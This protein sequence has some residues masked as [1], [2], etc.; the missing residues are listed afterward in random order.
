MKKFI[1][2]CLTILISLS[3]VFASN[4]PDG[5][6]K[7]EVDEAIAAGLIPAELQAEY[8]N[9]TT[10][11]EFC[12]LA[13]KL[14]E[15]VY[16]VSV[17]QVLLGRGKNIAPEDTFSD[18][19]N[20]YVLA[21]YAL[22]ITK[23]TG[24]G[25]F[26]P[27]LTL[28]RQQAARL[29]MQTAIVCDFY[30][31][32][33][34]KMN[35]TPA[36]VKAHYD[37][38]FSD[39]S[40]VAPWARKGV[41]F[42]KDFDVM[43][44]TGNGRFSPKTAYQKQQS[45]ITVYRLYNKIKEVSNPVVDEEPA[46]SFNYQTSLMKEA[47]LIKE[48][49][50]DE[51]KD[52]LGMTPYGKDYKAEYKGVLSDYNDEPKLTFDTAATIYYQL[53]EDRVNYKI[54]NDIYFKNLVNQVLIYDSSKDRSFYRMKT[55]MKN[56]IREAKGNVS[57]PR[58]FNTLYFNYQLNI[59]SYDKKDKVEVSL[60]ELNGE[61]VLHLDTYTTDGKYSDYWISL[62]TLM[63][64]QAV[65][66]IDRKNEKSVDELVLNSWHEEQQKDTSIF[67]VNSLSEF[68]FIRQ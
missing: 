57:Y 6:A 22:D 62:K 20:P 49:T 26:S 28:T 66:V 59:A 30:V 34:A 46:V 68:E 54:R 14:V 38:I 44:G 42:V 15:A 23:G 45:I 5:W 25:K 27:N 56:E 40:Q 67:D 50:L 41:I 53:N 43:K 35:G 48:L 10:R 39:M 18:T 55:D 37:S 63:P 13:V 58:R 51:A 36:E 60:E 33:E 7:P 24:N 3:F 31:D 8:Q 12:I 9:A 19:Q 2:L 52:Y 61:Q 21:A 4:Q 16:G 17:D 32:T 11:E 64:V 29:L 1:S 65:I 47:K